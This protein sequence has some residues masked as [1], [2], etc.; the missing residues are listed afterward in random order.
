[1][2]M[3]CRFKNSSLKTLSHIAKQSTPVYS[4]PGFLKHSQNFFMITDLVKQNGSSKAI[5]P[6]LTMPDAI[7]SIEDFTKR[8]NVD[9]PKEGVEKTPD[10][11]AETLTISHVEGKL[12]EIYMRQWGYDKCDF[13]VVANELCCDVIVWVLDPSTGVKITR[14]GTAAIAIMVD[15]APDNMKG[16]E[17]NQWA[18]NLANKKPNALKM[19]R[20]AVKALALKN[21]VQSLGVVFGRNLNRK[22]EDHPEDYYT[23]ELDA[24]EAIDLIGQEMADCQTVDDLKAIWEANPDLHNNTHFRKHFTSTKQRIQLQSK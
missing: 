2:S 11:K 13:S 15:R 20:P 23:Q 22:N 4:Y 18:L 9:P 1:M 19:N 21:A 6:I 10:G 8:L 7:R 16:Q 14:A 3:R 5:A 12:D 24:K 17:R